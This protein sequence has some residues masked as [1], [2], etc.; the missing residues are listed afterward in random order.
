[1]HLQLTALSPSSRSGSQLDSWSNKL[2]V[3]S[4]YDDDDDDDDDEVD[5]DNHDDADDVDEE[6]EE[7]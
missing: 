4:A 3:A 1:M 2:R 5:D 6:E 7:D